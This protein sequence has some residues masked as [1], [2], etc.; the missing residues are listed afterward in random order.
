LDK[1]S[2]KDTV[3]LLFSTLMIALCGILYELNIA[4]LATYLIGNSVMQY[5]LIIGAFMSS[6][7]IGSY[8][9][10]Y[11]KHNLLLVFF[12]IETAIGFIGSLSVLTI[13]YF[14]SSSEIYVFVI[15]FFII[16]LGTLIGLEIP[17]IGRII[18]EIKQNIRIT[19]ANLFSFDYIGS[20]IG[21]VALPLF[22]LPRFG[23]IKTSL[24]IGIGNL[25]I[26]ILVG[27]RF[28]ARLKKVILLVPLFLIF[29]NGILFFQAEDVQIYMD[30]KSY[31][32]KI[33]LTQQSKY[34]KIIMT[35]D[36]NDMRLFLDGNIQFS[37]KD[38]HRYHE[39]LVHIPM[40]YIKTY[41]PLKV[42]ILGGGDGLAARELLKYE[43]VEEITI[44]DLDEKIT[45]IAKSNPDL[46]NLNQKAMFSP[47]IKIVNQ[48]AYMFLFNT[49]QANK[50]T[51]FRKLWDL[52]IIDLPDPNNESL[53][54]LYS[55]TFYQII[56]ENLKK[57]GIAVTQATSPFHSRVVFWCIFHTV[58]SVGFK[59]VIPYQVEVPAFGNWGFVLFSKQSLE[60]YSALKLADLSYQFLNP[61]VLPSLFIFGNDVKEIPTQ[62][63]TI[64][65]PIIIDYYETS[66]QDF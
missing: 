14:Y 51:T 43:R 45:Q 44:C 64:Y 61:E 53:A 13:Y 65:K 2:N 5:S 9:S 38:E 57:N 23:S 62:I 29:L 59:S 8:L 12:W 27:F 24:L 22:L 4:A 42:L 17:L 10:K 35:K 21:C 47:K 66:W 40:G 37:S 41:D 33:I 6:F 26:S 60:H 20:M 36:K 7:G 19:M 28:R 50:K 46:I 39:S 49:I 56:M 16:S 58:Q 32:D 18:D 34:Q 31:E 30:Q 48:D 63:N 55:K 54:K 11:V 52:I 25:L 15:Y 1:Q 3:I